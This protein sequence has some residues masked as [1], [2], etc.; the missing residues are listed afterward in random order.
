MVAFEKRQ[1]ATCASGA[2]NR[3][4]STTTNTNT[5]TKKE[6]LFAPNHY[7]IPYTKKCMPVGLKV[8]PAGQRIVHSINHNFRVFCVYVCLIL[9]LGFGFWFLGSGSSQKTGGG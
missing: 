5:N 8:T 2:R 1:F 3:C 9:I 6:T 7:A 4:K